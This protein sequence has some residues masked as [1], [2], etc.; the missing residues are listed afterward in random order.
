MRTRLAWLFPRASE[1]R[2]FLKWRSAIHPYIFILTSSH[3][4][5]FTSSHPHLLTSSISFFSSSHL[6]L[7]IS[8]HHRQNLNLHVLT[9]P[10]HILKSSYHNIFF[11]SHPHLFTSSISFFSSYIFISSYLH[12]LYIIFYIFFFWD[13]LIY[14]SLYASCYTIFWLTYFTTSLFALGPFNELTFPPWPI[15]WPSPHGFGSPSTTKISLSSTSTY[16]S[17]ISS[18]TILCPTWM[19]TSSTPT[20][21][22]RHS[23]DRPPSYATIGTTWQLLWHPGTASLYSSSHRGL[24]IRLHPLQDHLPQLCLS[25]LCPGIVWIGRRHLPETLVP[26]SSS[27]STD[28]H[29]CH[30]TR[31]IWAQSHADQHSWC[32]T[33]RLPSL[34]NVPDIVSSTDFG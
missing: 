25:P 10:R 19:A 12:T 24:Q 4:H 5:I 14:F 26:T 22:S 3:A 17:R 29:D 18:F 1:R 27:F 15:L 13:I 2:V 8:S 21:S 16:S 30:H 7:F 9:S 34:A 31:Q 6:H 28:P 20:G 11:S 32:F 33:T 23:P